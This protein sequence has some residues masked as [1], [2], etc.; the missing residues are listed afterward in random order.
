MEL[1][2]KFIGLALVLLAIVHIIFPKYFDWKKEL[3]S[4]SLVNQEMMRIHTLFIALTVLL[5]GILC[6]TSSTELIETHLGKKICLGLGLFW[7][8]RLLI[9]FF[10]YSSA[11]WKGKFFETI[12]HV[13]FSLLWL[14]LTFIFFKIAFLN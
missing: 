10:G 7:S 3:S 6:L 1:H 8:I 4:L 14:Y 9:Q 12:V 11:L 13:F 5:M 2:L